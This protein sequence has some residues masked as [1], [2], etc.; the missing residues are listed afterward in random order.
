[1]PA[2]ASVSSQAGHS[3]K[4]ALGTITFLCH[5]FVQYLYLLYYLNSHLSMQKMLRFCFMV[6]SRGGFS[7]I[8]EKYRLTSPRLTAEWAFQGMP[9]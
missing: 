7:G 4:A 2:S 6:F 5:R 3:L 1:M 9:P 8:D